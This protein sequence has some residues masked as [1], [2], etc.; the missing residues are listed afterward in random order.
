M[1]AAAGRYPPP[2]FGWFLSPADAGEE[3]RLNASLPVSGGRLRPSREPPIGPR[4]VAGIAAGIALQIIL[5]L[6]LGLPEFARRLDLG[7]D[8]VRPDPRGVR[9]LDRPQRLLPLFLRRVEDR[10]AIGRT[11]IAALPVPGRRIVD[12]EE[13]L[14]QLAIADQAG[15]I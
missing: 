7:D 4:E 10:G 8:L 14:E 2:P 9:I 6:G 1:T 13:E 5:V 3:L 11:D 12:L 15:E